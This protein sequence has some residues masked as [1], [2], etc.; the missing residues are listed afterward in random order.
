MKFQ[1]IVNFFYNS[2]EPFFKN[3]CYKYRRP[4]NHMII[5]G[6]EQLRA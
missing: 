6:R 3:A 4:K 2:F 1:E 5:W